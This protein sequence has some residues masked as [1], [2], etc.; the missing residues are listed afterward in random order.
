MRYTTL[1]DA[2]RSGRQFTKTLRI[3]AFPLAAERV[4]NMRES[5]LPAKRIA[6]HP[7][8]DDGTCRRSQPR[9]RRNRTS[10]AREISDY[11]RS[12]ESAAGEKLPLRLKCPKLRPA[13]HAPRLAVL[14][15]APWGPGWVKAAFTMYASGT[16]KTNSWGRIPEYLPFSAILRSLVAA[17]ISLSSERTCC[18]RFNVSRTLPRWLYLS[19]ISL[20][21][22]TRYSSSST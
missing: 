22:P 9:N 18:G 4:D 1:P 21:V 13:Y 6:V 10:D 17:S 11:A 15:R 8:L 16:P 7:G 12:A 14:K 2:A 19:G 3:A 5:G 20:W